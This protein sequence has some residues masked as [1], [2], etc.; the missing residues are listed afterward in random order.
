MHQTSS[1]QSEIV[2]YMYLFPKL[3]VSRLKIPPFT[4]ARDVLEPLAQENR[5]KSE[6]RDILELCNILPTEVTNLSE[7]GF[8]IQIMC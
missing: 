2:L 4:R 8:S 3:S 1:Y 5:V 6:T 7:Y